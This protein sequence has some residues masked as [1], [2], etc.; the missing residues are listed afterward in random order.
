LRSAVFLGIRGNMCMAIYKL[1]QFF[2]DAVYQ[3]GWTESWYISGSSA[4]GCLSTFAAV[5]TARQALLMDSS[6]IFAIRASNVDTPR[7]SLYL[8]SGL[9]LVGTI[10]SATYPIAG[11]WDCLL[12]TLQSSTLNMFGHVFMHSVPAGIFVGRV[13]VPTHTSGIGWVANF[14]AW[15]SAIVTANLLK[16]QKGP[17]YNPVISVIGTRRTERR[18]GRPFDALRGR[19]SVA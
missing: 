13:Y 7:D 11:V 3:T 10:V 8:S 1:T 9:P 2:T 16:R 15:V 5:A 18:L 4:S 14:A 12:V 17:L 19:R 6:S